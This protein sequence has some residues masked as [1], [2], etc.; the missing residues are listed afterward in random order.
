MK[1]NTDL[2]N[3]F[4]GFQD[5]FL[6]NPDSVYLKL[7]LLKDGK[8]D[9]LIEILKTKFLGKFIDRQIV[10]TSE[11]SGAMTISELLS[12][13]EIALKEKNIPL[14]T[15]DNGKFYHPDT[16]ELFP[17]VAVPATSPI[18][19]VATLPKGGMTEGEMIAEAVSLK[20]THQHHLADYLRT[21]IFLVKN[22]F[23]AKKNTWII[24]F[25]LEMLNDLPCE[26]CCGRGGDGGFC[27]GVGR[28]S[29][30]RGWV[31]ETLS[32]LLSN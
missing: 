13:L 3:L 8:N 4:A 20:K 15:Y 28:V 29:S 21:V 31:G 7:E 26:F 32:I 10:C 2:F 23:F 24:G 11:I 14:Y 12:E 22:N 1:N 18:M 16:L 5:Q 9:E 6:L 17:K 25:L 30:S 19:S 27:L